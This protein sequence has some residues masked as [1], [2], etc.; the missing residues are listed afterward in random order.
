MRNFSKADETIISLW[1]DLSAPV[2]QEMLLLDN[3]EKDNSYKSKIFSSLVFSWYGLSALRGFWSYLHCM[4]EI[5][6]S[7]MQ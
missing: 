6:V 7:L 1:I 5:S 2:M 4:L 3:M